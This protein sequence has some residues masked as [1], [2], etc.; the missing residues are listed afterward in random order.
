MLVR[1]MP[2]GAL[3]GGLHLMPLHT[4]SSERFALIV[5]GEAK[6]AEQ[7]DLHPRTP[8]KRLQSNINRL[9]AFTLLEDVVLQSLP[10]NTSGWQ[11]RSNR[12]VDR[13]GAGSRHLA[14][15]RDLAFDLQYQPH[16]GVGGKEATV[17]NLSAHIGRHEGVGYDEI[18]DLVARDAVG[19]RRGGL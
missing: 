17:H 14:D 2:E 3:G 18:V 5:F 15:E 7:L 4:Q 10:V 8:V 13:E 12:L 6:Y 1:R 16:R 11:L 19:R 9:A